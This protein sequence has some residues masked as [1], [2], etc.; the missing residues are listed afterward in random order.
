MK[1]QIDRIGELM[2]IN[3]E[4]DFKKIFKYEPQGS[5]FAPGRVNLIGEHIDYNGGYV[6]PSALSLGTYAAAAKRNDKKI[7]FYSVNFPQNGVIEVDLS[8]IIY[9]KEDGWTNYP[10]GIISIFA[11]E[12]LKIDRGFDIVYNGNIPNGAGLSSSASIEVCTGVL[13]NDFFKFG[14]DNV[15]IAKLSQKAENEFVG[16]N[17]G[18]MD[19][20]ASAMGKKE[21][22]IFLDCSSLDYKYV[23]LELKEMSIVIINTNK[24]RE[25]A[26]SKYNERRRECEDALKD[27]QTK[28]NIKNLCSLGPEEF[29]NNKDLI[30][31][32]V[33]RKRAKHAIYENARTIAACKIL[34]KNDV[35]G[36]GKLMKESHDSL[37]Y[38]YEVSCKELDAAVKLAL[39]HQGTIGARMTG[40]GFGGC[41]V[42]IVKNG[43]IED[44]I[45]DI[46]PEYKKITGFDAEF[47][48]A[49]AE[50][51][52]CKL[53][54]R[55]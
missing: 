4:A 35:A 21:R 27:L 18:I 37:R 48:I 49:C 43:D 6:F 26:G 25:L 17:C 20:F 23:P 45:K 46:K 32:P 24:K 42:C 47:Y 10:K 33:A 16:M 36:F 15:A 39:D 50:T 2:D 14:L 5:F 7:R 11:A 13:L 1:R 8:D 40:A 9:R 29:E 22:A 3:I 51:G 41:A 34:E 12:G 54:K 38:D 28:L 53:E 44:F 30:K 52:A 55:L 31:N 19:Q